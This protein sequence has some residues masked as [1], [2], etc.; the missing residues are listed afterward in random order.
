M[1]VIVA[2]GLLS[3]PPL[4]NLW[5]EIGRWLW[6]GIDVGYGRWL[7]GWKITWRP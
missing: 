3:N 7:S 6:L 1:D 4:L 5:I 2:L